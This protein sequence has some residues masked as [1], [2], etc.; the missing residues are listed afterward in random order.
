MGG[1]GGRGCEMEM[2]VV[3]LVLSA[4]ILRDWWSK[5]VANGRGGDEV[6]MVEIGVVVMD[7]MVVGRNLGGFGDRERKNHG[8]G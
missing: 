6:V 4:L 8:V 5:V 3:E 1:D 7:E 2:V